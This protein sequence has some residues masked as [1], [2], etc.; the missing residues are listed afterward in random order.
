MKYEEL[1]FVNQQ[2]AGML[3]SGIPLEGGLRQ[4]CLDMQRGSL[5]TE[6]EKLEVDLAQGTPFHQAIAARQLPE[7]YR[8]MVQAGAR[9]N[10]LPGMLTLLA[11]YYQRANSLWTRLK[12]LMVYP[13]IVLFTSLILSLFFAVIFNAL[14][15]SGYRE[16]NGF[17][18]QETAGQ[19][20]INVG[21]YLPAI[22]LGLIACVALAG[23]TIPALRRFLRWRLPGFR[24]S[25]LSLA[26][27]TIKLMLQSGQSLNQAIG[28]LQQVEKTTPAGEDLQR[29]QR[30]LAEGRGKFSEFAGENKIFPPLF[31]W[32]VAQGGEDVVTGFGRAA[33]V[34]YARAM[35][36]MDLLL[37]AALPVSVLLLG[38][39]IVGQVL[40]AVRVFSSMLGSLGDLE[41]PPAGN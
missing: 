24:E 31:V 20:S 16:L 7:F 10:D 35:H 18:G 8:R 25:S 1:A 39:M 34:Y 12:G 28:I 36:R 17:G 27:S 29:W 3:K 41:A 15:G 33:E 4:V 38:L 2:L 30:R 11:D 19:D 6:L 21:L 26:A 23:V 37:Y 22:F 40:P 9:S 14:A 32:L 13:L 5:R